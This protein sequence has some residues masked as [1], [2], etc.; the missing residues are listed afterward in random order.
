MSGG[1]GYTKEYFNNGISSST[2]A[3]IHGVDAIFFIDVE[4]NETEN[5]YLFIT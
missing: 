4:L 1:A 5:G 2:K 3:N